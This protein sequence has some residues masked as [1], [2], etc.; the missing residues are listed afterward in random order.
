MLKTSARKYVKVD[1]YCTITNLNLQHYRKKLLLLKEF[2]V[3]K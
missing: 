1:T 3:I 2:E